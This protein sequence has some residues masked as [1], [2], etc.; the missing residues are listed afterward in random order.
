MFALPE[1]DQLDRYAAGHLSHVTGEPQ[2]VLLSLTDPGWPDGTSA[3][4]G[5]TWVWRRYDELRALLQSAERGVRT[6]NATPPTPSSPG[7]G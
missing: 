1:E 3:S 4:G 7:A 5:R 2:L 6:R